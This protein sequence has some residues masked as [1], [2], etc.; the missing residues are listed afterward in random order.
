VPQEGV[1]GF[2]RVVQHARDDKL[3]VRAE[4]AE[5]PRGLGRMTIVGAPRPEVSHCLL[6]AV[7]H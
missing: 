1:R 3:L 2:R 6:H 4:V 5:D 7:P